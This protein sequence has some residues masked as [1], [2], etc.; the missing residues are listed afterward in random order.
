M[1]ILVTKLTV[2]YV[3]AIVVIIVYWHSYKYHQY[4]HFTVRHVALPEG[5]SVLYQAQLDT[6]L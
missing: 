3:A 1:L 2:G 4:A 5:W 6:N